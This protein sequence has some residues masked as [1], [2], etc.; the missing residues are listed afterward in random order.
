MLNNKINIVI[1]GASGHSKVVID[2][3]ERENKYNI[4]GLIDSFKTPGE[5][6]FNYEILG[7]ENDIPF[8]IKKFSISSGII[9]IGDNWTRKVMYKKIQKISPELSFIN[10]IH[11]NAVIGK[12]VSIGSGSVIM[13]GAIV[14]SDTIIGK[15]CIVNTNSSLGHDS[16]LK[17]YSSLAPGVITG[18]NVIIGC[19]T[20]VSLGAK[21]IQNIEIGEHSI[22]GAGS[23]VINDIGDFILAY[24]SPAKT[25]RTIE[26]GEKYLFKL[27]SKK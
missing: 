22:I 16:E 21:V 1:I 24:G 20:A 3:I 26:K 7:D 23:L 10:A 15:F 9:A 27:D 5:C 14:N 2:I 17:N 6:I 11:P 8:L 19:C 25:I 12:N 18:G 4:V 13:P